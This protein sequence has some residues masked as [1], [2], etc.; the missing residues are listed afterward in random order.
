MHENSKDARVNISDFHSFEKVKDELFTIP[1]LV[2]RGHRI[3]IPETLRE[4]VIDIA[5]EGHMGIVKTKALIR[6][7]VWFPKI[8]QM[9]EEKVKS[10]LA[11]QATTPKNAK[12]PL[13]MSKLPKAP[14][15][16]LSI[17]FGLAPT[18]SSEYLLVLIDD[19]S[20]FP[21][22]QLVRSTS[23]NAFIPCLDKIF[24]EYGIPEVVR[25][26]NGPPFNSHE[27]N[28]FLKHLGFTHR[29]VAPYWPRANGEVGRFMRT[30]KKVIKAAVM[31][32][33]T[34]KQEMYK[35]LRNY[36]ATPHTST[37]TSPA[38]A[39][40][41]RPM[42]TRLPQLGK[43]P[44]SSDDFI[45]GNDDLAKLKMKY[46]AE[47]K[48]DFKPIQLKKDDTVL[49]KNE[50][51]SKRFPPYDPSPYQV[52]EKKGSMVT[53]RR[54]SSSVTRNSSF[55]KQVP[56]QE[57]EEMDCPEPCV[58]ERSPEN[59]DIFE[60]AKREIQ[61]N[62]DVSQNVEPEVPRTEKPSQETAMPRYPRRVRK[63]ANRYQS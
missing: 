42:K 46:F 57:N 59:P 63:K 21:A 10:C 40:F 27:F 7:K 30:I 13:Q 61:V 53:A 23:S 18:G 58:P 1:D 3:V 35:F 43:E 34:W 54:E 28:E 62:P 5:H 6:E 45:R 51:K 14:W 29:K 16:E 56:K 26:D 37:K 47:L 2:L 4:K 50:Y 8:D 32:R 22:V 31:E 52:G 38:N 9:V 60:D 15:T 17:D 25:S 33:K 36:R 55:F 41:G 24:A 20:R 39:L 49:L 12:E 48:S 44:E 19:Y 11:C